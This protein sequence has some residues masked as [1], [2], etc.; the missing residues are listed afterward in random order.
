MSEIKE[1]VDR[2][3]EDGVMTKQEHESLIEQIH[4]DGVIDENESEQIARV[5]KLI[6]AGELVIVDEVREK[7]EQK[8]QE[9]QEAVAEQNKS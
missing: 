6:S 2:Y 3:V 9:H 8:R 7:F 4:K 1:L 5:F